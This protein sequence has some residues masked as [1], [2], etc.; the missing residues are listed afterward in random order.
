MNIHSV[1]VNEPCNIMVHI[2]QAD[3]R[4]SVMRL[5]GANNDYR[6]ITS[7]SFMTRH[8]RLAGCMQYN[9]GIGYLVISLQGTHSRV[10]NYRYGI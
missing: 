9:I 6:D 4:W 8:E 7:S 10:Y 5:A 3:R 1:T 2:L